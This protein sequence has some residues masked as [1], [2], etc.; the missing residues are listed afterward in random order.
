MA[1]WPCF[2][3]VTGRFDPSNGRFGQPGEACSQGQ[4][5]MITEPA[6]DG[7]TRPLQEFESLYI[8]VA[9]PAVRRAFVG[10]HRAESS[11]CAIAKEV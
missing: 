8:G 5:S 10:Y 2:E 11:L 9:T 7:Q 3:P 1:E 4:G 6:A